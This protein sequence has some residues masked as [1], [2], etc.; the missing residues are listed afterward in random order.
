M[1]NITLAKGHNDVASKFNP[2]GLHISIQ[3][4]QP[5]LFRVEVPQQTPVGIYTVHLVSSI[6]EPSTATLTK[7]IFSNK[8]SGILDPEFLISKKCPSVG[9]IT[10]PTNLTVTV[11][12]PLD[13]NDQFRSFWNTY[14]QPISIIAGG[15]AGGFASLIFSRVNRKT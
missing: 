6:L 14:G 7:P 1:N 10:S 12:P 4:I 5:P 15:F 3:R 2:N 13:V 11:I 8:V 9:Y